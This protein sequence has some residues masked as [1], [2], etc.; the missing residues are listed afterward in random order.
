MAKK[1]FEEI[2][3]EVKKLVAEITEVEEKELLENVKFSEDLGIDSMMALEIIASIE[4][5]YKVVVPEEKIPTLRSLG[6]VYKVLQPLLE[7]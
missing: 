2:K 1:N 6:D 4:K 3:L 7:K 5:K